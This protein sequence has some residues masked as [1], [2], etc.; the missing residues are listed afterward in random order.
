MTGTPSVDSNPQGG[1]AA[2]ADAAVDNIHAQPATQAPIQ[3]TINLAPVSPL[4]LDASFVF[5]IISAEENSTLD[6]YLAAID[7]IVK[8]VIGDEIMQASTFEYPSVKSIERDGKCIQSS[9]YKVSVSLTYMV[10]PCNQPL[11]WTPQAARKLL[12]VWSIYPF[13]SSLPTL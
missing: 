4:K 12:G 13:P 10:S 8:S 9:K 3:P 5:G 6:G 7:R 1:F 11:S 2:P